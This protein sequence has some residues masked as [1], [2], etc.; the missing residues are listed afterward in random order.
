LPNAAQH[1]S[2]HR[3]DKSG[4]LPVSKVLRSK[5]DITMLPTQYHVSFPSWLGLMVS[6]AAF[7]LEHIS[8]LVAPSIFM[9]TAVTGYLIPNENHIGS[10]FIAL[11]KKSKLIMTAVSEFT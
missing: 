7:C 9:K 1:P 4:V 10:L 6:Q 11:S 8:V 2:V 5:L 3:I